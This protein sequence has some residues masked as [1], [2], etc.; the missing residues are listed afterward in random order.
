[1]IAMRGGLLAFYLFLLIAAAFLSYDDP[2]TRLFLN[3]FVLIICLVALI[4]RLQKLLIRTVDE[5]G[6]AGNDDDDNSDKCEDDFTSKSV[7]EEVDENKDASQD[8]DDDDKCED[9]FPSK[10]DADEEEV[11]DND[12]SQDELKNLRKRGRGKRGPDKKPRK[13]P[14]CPECGQTKDGCPKASRTSSIQICSKVWK[15]M[16]PEH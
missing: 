14:T 3:I 15:D 11:D 13:K 12:A 16:A 9:D 2:R 8:D 10:K 4:V 5:D 1:M 6:F 7:E